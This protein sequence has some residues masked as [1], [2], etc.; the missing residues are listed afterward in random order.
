MK[1]PMIDVARSCW[2]DS[3]ELRDFGGG[4]LR[5]EACGTLV[6]QSGLTDDE[7]RVRD[8]EADYY[9][10][11]YWLEHQVDDLGLPDIYARARQDLPDRC[12]H[13]LQALLRYR[14]PPAKVLEVGAGH[15]AYTALLRA[16][17]YDAVGL[18]VS[19][20]VARF[21]EET[22]GIPYLVGPVEG[23]ELDS[24]SFD[25][26]V[27]N[28]VLEHLADPFETMRRCGELLKPG[29][30]LV[31][32]TP[33]Y[34]S[35]RSY[36]ELV[37]SEDLFLEHM[38]SPSHEHL[39][40]FSRSAL[41][42]LLDRIGLGFRVFE[43]PVFRYDMF[44]FASAERL[45]GADDNDPE[46]ALATSA[47]G[48]LVLALVDLRESLQVS[49]TDRSERLRVINELDKQLAIAEK[50]RAARLAIIEQLNVALAESEADREVRLQGL[51]QLDAAL[52]ASE[53]D[54]QAR[55]ARIEGLEATLRVLESV[56][57]AARPVVTRRWIADQLD[58]ILHP[59]DTPSR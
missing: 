59:R 30:V 38:G 2:C 10:K 54:R 23:Q 55:L 43:R 16:A 6:G 11:R 19:P 12:V 22:F 35:G 57:R 47:V 41:E 58:A 40:L 37:E 50:D 36:D 31:I 32:Q 24:A 34:P 8:D 28:D 39:Y 56:L 7:T 42:Q 45:R 5:C 25:V 3:D 44:C 29:G 13:W 15:G 51:Q 18:D 27:A 20:W 26:V 52:R 53:A 14:R 49:E 4:Y 48:R 9:G 33:E 21:A 17:G 46:G 1:R